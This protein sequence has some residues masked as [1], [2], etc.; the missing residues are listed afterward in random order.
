MLLLREDSFIKARRLI[1]TT[2]SQNRKTAS[3]KMFNR[4]INVYRWNV[5]K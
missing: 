3:G 4:F 1:G 2:R 5:F